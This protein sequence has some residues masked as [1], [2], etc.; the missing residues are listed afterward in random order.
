M[1][2]VYFT[3]YHSECNSIVKRTPSQAKVR[4]MHFCCRG[5]YRQW[6]K[7]PAGRKFTSDSMKGI[8]KNQTYY[9]KRNVNLYSGWIE[10]CKRNNVDLGEIVL[11]EV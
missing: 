7:S 11:K 2:P 8:P 9:Y 4:K 6:I 3:C 10:W 5:C 1:M